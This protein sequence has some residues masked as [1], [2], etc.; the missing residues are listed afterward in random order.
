MPKSD[1][2]LGVAERKEI[3][4]FT[5][6][7]FNNVRYEIRNHANR[8]A[9]EREEE[10]RAE[11]TKDVKDIQAKANKLVERAKALQVDLTNLLAETRSKGISLQNP[12]SYRGVSLFSIDITS[13]VRWVT[14]ET[15][16]KVQ[17]SNAEI[18]RQVDEA[19][20]EVARRRTASERQLLMAAIQSEDAKALLES[21]PTAAEMFSIDTKALKA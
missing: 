2:T 6:Q 19:L 5:E 3:R 16:K 14:E 12:N 4:A 17:A 7:E 10:I 11:V 13:D 8:I 15:E 1:G 20:A 9:S 18:N 21:V